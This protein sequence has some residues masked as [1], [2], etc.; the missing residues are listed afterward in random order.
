MRTLT[1][2]TGNKARVFDLNTRALRVN[3]L[4]IGRA[5]V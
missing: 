4:K 5:H 1:Y 3:Q 2:T